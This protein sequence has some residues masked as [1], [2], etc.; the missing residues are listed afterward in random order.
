M[1]KKQNKIWRDSIKEEYNNDR[2]EMNQ[3]KNYHKKS[4]NENLNPRIM[5]LYLLS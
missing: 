3:S 5:N 1:S 4:F 2:E